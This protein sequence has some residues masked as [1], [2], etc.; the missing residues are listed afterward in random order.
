MNS[1]SSLTNHE[2]RKTNRQRNDSDL[3][4]EGNIPNVDQLKIRVSWELKVVG[5]NSCAC[6]FFFIFLI[7]SISEIF[8]YWIC[9]FPLI[10][11]SIMK[12]IYFSVSMHYKWITPLKEVT[13]E[14][15]GSICLLLYY[16]CFFI[17]IDW[18]STENIYQ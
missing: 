4:V 7:G 15:I 8:P 1:V 17:I 6:S 3:A 11:Y 10:I 13:K 18:N 9:M 16:V 5:A 2:D 14:I 12:T